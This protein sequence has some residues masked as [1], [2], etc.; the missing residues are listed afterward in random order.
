[1]I[2]LNYKIHL[3]LHFKYKPLLNIILYLF[4]LLISINDSFLYCYCMTENNNE[5]ST[6]FNNINTDIESQEQEFQEQE[7]I[8]SL[9]TRPTDNDVLVICVT[10][11]ITSY[12]LYIGTIVIK[13]LS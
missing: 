12:I 7:Y 6:V 10:T 8:Y 13:S 5:Y 3:L 9:T 11:I 2:K 4:I 1:M